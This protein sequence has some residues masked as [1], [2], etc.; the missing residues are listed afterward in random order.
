MNGRVKVVFN[1]NFT[2][3]VKCGYTF[4]QVAHITL[5]NSFHDKSFTSSYGFNLRRVG[6]NC[7]VGQKLFLNFL[8]VRNFFFCSL[9]IIT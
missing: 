2:D 1:N 5:L 7:W 3:L 9:A 8:L 4:E 6:D